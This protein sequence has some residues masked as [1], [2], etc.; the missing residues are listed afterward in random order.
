MHLGPVWLNAEAVGN[1]P[2]DVV[3][4][5]LKRLKTTMPSMS[6]RVD[7]SVGQ[8]VEVIADILLVGFRKPGSIAVD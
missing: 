5:P 3:N 1:L 8:V 2:A 4:Q 7:I 6:H